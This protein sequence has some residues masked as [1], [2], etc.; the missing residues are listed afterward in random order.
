MAWNLNQKQKR[1]VR[2][3]MAVKSADKR[4]FERILEERLAI[5]NAACEVL[6]SQGTN[7]VNLPKDQS[8]NLQNRTDENAPL[9]DAVQ[10]HAQIV[11]ESM[12]KHA[13]LLWLASQMSD[14]I[15]RESNKIARRMI[16]VAVGCAL[17]SL[18]S[19]PFS[20]VRLLGMIGF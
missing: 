13:N 18:P 9:L 5:L 1:E 4:N 15:A 11:S 10:A 2:Q 20:I 14:E 19:L 8:T 16:L 12:Q 7:G 3:K 17:I 6:K